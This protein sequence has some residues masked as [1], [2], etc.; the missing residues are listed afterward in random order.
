MKRLLPMVLL[1]GLCACDAKPAGAPSSGAPS[2]AAS[3]PSTA[4]A[5][6]VPLPKGENT[7]YF[8]G[9]ESLDDISFSSKTQITNIIG[10]SHKVTGSA[11]VD[12]DAGT[13]KCKI[14][15]PTA[16]LNS[17]MSDRDNAMHGKTWLESKKFTTIEFESTK[18]VPAKP[19][20]GWKI[21]GKFTF[22]GVTQDLSIDADVKRI[23]ADVAKKYGLGEGACIQV[24]TTFKVK[25]E[26]YRIAIDKSAI[27]TVEPV[28]TVGVNIIGSTVKPATSAEVT[29]ASDDAPVIQRVPAVEPAGLGGVLYRFGKKPQ[30][31]TI[32]ASSQGEVGS[33]TAQ[34]TAI[35]GFLGIEKDKGMGKARFR[36]MADHFTTRVAALDKQL[37]GPAF[38]DSKQF[39][40][41]TFESTKLAKKDEATWNAE[42]NLTLH[43]VTKPVAF[44]VAVTEISKETVEKA[45]WGDQPGLGFDATLK[46]KLSDYGIKIPDELAGRM[47]DEVTVTLAL[48]ALLEEEK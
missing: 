6:A 45:H 40:E 41:I 20:T 5:S 28:W 4:P 21:D 8:G 3:T 14:V 27:A 31:T 12:F 47:K 43:G 2:T 19:P 35:S 29:S 48:T 46:L 37:L 15:V 39:K 44:P 36:L 23:R 32:K 7:Y 13:G 25:L 9:D 34:N 38:L 10:H 26:D 33:V 11:A 24:S 17:G 16:S 30:L 22:H 1:A 18:A 42:G